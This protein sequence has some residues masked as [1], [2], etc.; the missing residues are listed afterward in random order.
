MAPRKTKAKGALRKCS[1]CGHP[2]CAHCSRH[3]GAVV[4]DSPKEA[5]SYRSY[6]RELHVAKADMMAYA[7]ACS[8]IFPTPETW[9]DFCVCQR[10]DWAAAACRFHYIGA[11]LCWARLG[12][13]PELEAQ[14]LEDRIAELIRERRTARGS[15]AL[16]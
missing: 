8:G 4:F 7:Y 10:A 6:M 11:E 13:T 15:E 14:A 12:V 5:A 16:N 2:V 3:I 1:R 9:K